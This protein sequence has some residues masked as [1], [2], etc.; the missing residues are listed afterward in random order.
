MLASLLFIVLWLCTS[1]WLVTNLI[2][3]C[4][5]ITAIAS[6][7]LPSLFIA[8]LMLS[9]FWAY[10][11]FWVFISPLIFRSSVMETVAVGVAQLELP[12][13]LKIPRLLLDASSLPSPGSDLYIPGFFGLFNYLQALIKRFG[14]PNFLMLGLGDIILPGFALNFFYRRDQLLEHEEE[15]RELANISSQESTQ[16]FQP[17][18]EIEDEESSN[19][20][21]R[22]APSPNQPQTA[23]PRRLTYYFVAQMGYIFG[24]LLTFFMLIVLKRGQPALLYL[25]PCTLAPPIV[26]AW[27]RKQLGWLW[28]PLEDA[29]LQA[30]EADASQVDEE[31]GEISEGNLNEE[32]QGQIELDGDDGDHEVSLDRERAPRDLNL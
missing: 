12:M 20:V 27:K 8:T 25:V 7:A 5:A 22:K 30:L 21:S 14:S 28:R 18:N 6:M 11:I 3:A 13:L 1:N 23:K 17:G 29:Q 31:R 4:L 9:V 2:A 32:D 10:D 24:L 16:E 26:L 19:R 15:M